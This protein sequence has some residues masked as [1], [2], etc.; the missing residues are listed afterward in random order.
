MLPCVLVLNLSKGELAHRLVKRLYRLTNKKNTP[1]QI[2]RRYRR[3]RHFGTSETLKPSEEGISSDGDR[4][5]RRDAANDPPEFHHTITNSR[6]NPVELASFS[7][8]R[9]PATKVA[10]SSFVVFVY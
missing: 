4:T 3:A 9:D 6:N 1:E 2:A 8:T 5:S 7:T 10:L